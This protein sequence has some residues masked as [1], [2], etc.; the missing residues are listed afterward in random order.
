MPVKYDIL[1]WEQ[2][3]YYHNLHYREPTAATAE[4]HETFPTP[5]QNLPEFQNQSS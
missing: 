3:D 5:D 4:R 1:F 2:G